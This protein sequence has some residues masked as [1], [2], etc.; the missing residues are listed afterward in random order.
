MSAKIQQFFG[1]D[2]DVDATEIEEFFG[3]LMKSTKGK[4]SDVD[5]D[6]VIDAGGGGWKALDEMEKV[7][8]M[9][10]IDAAMQSKFGD[11]VRVVASVLVEFR[12]CG[13][14]FLLAGA[15][16]WR[17]IFEIFSKILVKNLHIIL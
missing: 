2:A 4:I 11:S 17:M 7:R 16:F 15:E 10:Q 6:K 8:Q 3:R 14:I 1:G 13:S 5:I 9:G 12:V